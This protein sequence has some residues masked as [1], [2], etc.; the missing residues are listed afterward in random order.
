MVRGL[1][2]FCN[3]L[4]AA[5]SVIASCA[6]HVQPR[7][8]IMELRCCSVVARAV[9]SSAVWLVAQGNLCA[10]CVA[11]LPQRV[12]CCAAGMRVARAISY[13]VSRSTY[14]CCI[15]ASPSVVRVACGWR[16][17]VPCF[18]LH[19]MRARRALSA[20]F[21]SACSLNKAAQKQRQPSSSRRNMSAPW[22]R[23]R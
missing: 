11:C 8:I 10:N 7:L 4:V 21:Y 6:L 2:L 9:L 5:P 16:V 20:L 23:V 17:P 19:T 22:C 18:G 14:N 3:T 13:A 15:C 1:P 12:S